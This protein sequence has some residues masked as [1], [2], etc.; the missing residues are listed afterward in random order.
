MKRRDTATALL[1]LG[2]TPLAAFAQAPKKVWR[3]GYLV[4]TGTGPS[5]QSEAFKEGLR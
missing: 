5:A 1:T 4:T 2:A 3:L